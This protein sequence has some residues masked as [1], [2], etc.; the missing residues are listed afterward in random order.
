MRR[1]AKQAR[2]QPAKMPTLQ[3]RQ[4]MAQLAGQRVAPE[5]RAIGKD[6]NKSEQRLAFDK[7]PPLDYSE[8][9]REMLSPGK[10]EKLPDMKVFD[11]N[12]SKLEQPETISMASYPR[13]GNTLCR[14]WVERTTGIFTGSDGSN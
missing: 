1:N 2:P 5:A 14:T 10:A 11:P 3:E 9:R 4:M 13:S 6:V 8:Y 12:V 7:F